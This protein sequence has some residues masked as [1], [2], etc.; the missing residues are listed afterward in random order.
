MTTYRYTCVGL[1]PITY[2]PSCQ[3]DLGAE[4]QFAKRMAKRRFGKRGTCLTISADHWTR[5]ELSTT[6]TASI[7]YRGRQPED[8]A[9][10]E[11]IQFTVSRTPVADSYDPWPS[12]ARWQ[13]R[14]A[15]D[16]SA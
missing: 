13:A 14:M 3:A 1:R 4:W 5:D 11:R 16:L 15:G 7:G 2:D 6:Y 8:A 10:W 12:E 9:Y